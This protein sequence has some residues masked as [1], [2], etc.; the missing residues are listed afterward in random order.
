MDL[1]DTKGALLAASRAFFRAE[2]LSISK[3]FGQPPH[4]AGNE[5]RQIMIPLSSPSKVE[6][7]KEKGRLYSTG[8]QV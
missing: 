8:F 2:E 4:H 7:T 5:A 6:P 1:D 3:L